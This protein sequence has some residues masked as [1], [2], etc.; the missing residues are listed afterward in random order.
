MHY[1]LIKDEETAKHIHELG[2]S[3][4][5][6]SPFRT[7]REASLEDTLETYLRATKPWED[8]L[9][10]IGYFDVES[11]DLLG[12]VLLS[13]GPLWYNQ[14]RLGVYELCLVATPEGA[15]RGIARATAAVLKGFVDSGMASVAEAGSAMSANPSQLENAYRKAGFSTFK[16]FVMETHANGRS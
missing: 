2:W 9:A 6:G 11:G 1:R 4:Q 8:T 12:S 14:E 13:I 16:S 7:I 15:G 3:V 10:L 5:E